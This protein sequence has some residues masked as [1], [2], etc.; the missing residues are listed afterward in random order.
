MRLSSRTLIVVLIM[1]LI[2]LQIPTWLTKGG[3]LSVWQQQAELVKMQQANSEQRI[4]NAQ[5]KADVEELIDSRRGQAAIEER[6]RYN[7]GMLKT[8][9]IFIQFVESKPT[10]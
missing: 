8:D 5:L 1:A 7:L 10:N 6:A 9:E 2:L 4:K 3:W